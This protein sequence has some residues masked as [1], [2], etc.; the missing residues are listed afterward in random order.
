MKKYLLF[1]IAVCLSFAMYGQTTL[2]S[3]TGDGGFENGATPAL[4]NWTALASGVDA[5]AVGATPTPTAGTNC[6]YIST[7]GGT[8]WTYSLISTIEHLYYDVTIPAGQPKVTLT[9][10][11]KA[12]GLS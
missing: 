1:L 2:I 11:W 10:K 4:N 6:G 9:F 12:G 5:W 8:T 7:D 3:P